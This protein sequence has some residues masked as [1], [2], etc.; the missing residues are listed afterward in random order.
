MNKRITIGSRGSKLAL[1]YAQKAKDK[2]IENTNLVD[3][4]IIIKSITT[5]GDQ[6]HD[7]RLSDV[8]GKGLLIDP[9]NAFPKL[10]PT[11]K[12]TIKPGPAVDAT[13]SISLIFFPLS[14]IAFSTIQSIFSICDLAANSGTTPPNSLCM[15]TWLEIML[16]KTIG[17]PSSF[18][19]IN[20]AAVSSQL[21]SIPRIK[22]FLLIQIVFNNCTIPIQVRNKF[23]YE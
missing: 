21:D 12:Q 18:S 6:I 13:A 4:D 7:T 19:V 20:E 15:S 14:S 10:K 1:L 23:F 3:G 11:D 16:L 2:I 17:I 8:G 22:G 5:K 9:A